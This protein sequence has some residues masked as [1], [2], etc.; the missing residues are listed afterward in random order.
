MM[1]RRR[2][3]A[4]AAAFAA[5]PASAAQSWSGRA[6]GA[7]VQITIHGP[8]NIS[9]P[10]LRHARAVLQR[11]EALFSLYKPSSTLSAL[12][13]SG[14]L[15]APAPEF[16]SLLQHADKVHHLTDG[17][18][19]P[20]IQPVWS[21]MAR[22]EDPR[23]AIARMGW[24]HVMFGRK[25]VRLGKDQALTFNGIAQGF[26]SDLVSAG[27]RHHGAAKTLVNLG[28]FRANGGPWRI[29]I[30]DPAAGL[31]GNHTITDSALAT[32]S[33]DAMAL[34][35]GHHIL[36]PNARTIWSSVTIE[37]TNATLAD[38]LSTAATMMTQERIAALLANKDIMR[39]TLVDHTGDVTSLT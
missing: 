32:S 35:A 24:R 33:P 9:G 3:L 31:V 30:E 21:A 4:I 20:T 2:F 38:G 16:L 23:T 5:A 7:N 39:I 15:S 13:R 1:D 26:A 6:L 18:F 22:G 37:A 34:G 12:N 19:D 36:H 17:L 14:A 25:G 29:G 10:A 11:V 8:D 28:E 27:L